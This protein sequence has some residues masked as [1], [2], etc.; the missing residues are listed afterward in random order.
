MPRDARGLKG[1]AGIS[2]EARA[3]VGRRR[4]LWWLGREP[5]GGK[6]REVWVWKTFNNRA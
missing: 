5:K 1:S 3:V 4:N 6:P 2:Y